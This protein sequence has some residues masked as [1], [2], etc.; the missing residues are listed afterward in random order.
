MGK[1]SCTTTLTGGVC[2]TL[3]QVWEGH[4][5]SRE[6]SE[7]GRCPADAP[8]WPAASP[9]LL[10]SDS[11]ASRPSLPKSLSLTVIFHSAKQ[12]DMFHFYFNIFNYVSFYIAVITANIILY[13][14]VL[15]SA[16]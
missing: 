11:L 2:A 7:R 10:G 4:R 3:C 1:R 5:Q 16:L 12:R 14:L 8:P 6:A 15:Y 13:R 9:A